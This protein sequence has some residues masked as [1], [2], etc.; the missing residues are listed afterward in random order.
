[1]LFMFDL[2]FNKN[3]TNYAQLYIIFSSYIFNQ[4]NSFTDNLFIKICIIFVI[5]Y[6]NKKKD[7]QILWTYASLHLVKG[8]KSPFPD[9]LNGLK[10]KKL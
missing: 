6:L 7:S 9:L 2:C 3:I 8:V 10:V 5:C 4:W 1:M